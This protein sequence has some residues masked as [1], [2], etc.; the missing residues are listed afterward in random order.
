VGKQPAELLE[1]PA[2]S[3]RAKKKKWKLV[4]EKPLVRFWKWYRRKFI[5]EYLCDECS[6][7]FVEKPKGIQVE[8]FLSGSSVA[9]VF[10]E[11]YF[12]RK[13]FHVELS[14]TKVKGDKIVLCP[15]FTRDHL[16]DVAEV[17]AMAQRFIDNDSPRHKQR[18]HRRQ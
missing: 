16:V 7:L 11:E 18:R 4:R 6:K 8:Q 14:R 3:P 5:C 13:N 15:L 10:V 9:Q 2:M 12:G 17:A 1:E